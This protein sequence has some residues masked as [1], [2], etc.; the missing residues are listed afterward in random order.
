MTDVHD[1][2]QRSY[3]MSRIRGKDTKPEKTLRSLL[4]RHGFRFRLNVTGLPGKPDI[5]LPKHRTVIFVHGCYWHRHP[6]CKYATT[7]ATNAEF[8]MEKFKRN[9]ERDNENQTA[10]LGLG[11][12]V[13]VVWEC[14]LKNAQEDVLRE[15]VT[16]LNRC[17]P[18]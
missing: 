1:S 12:K 14:G 8:W 5:V 13:V 7:P 15:V 4:H 11:W 16:N 6:G 9:V 2:K 18:A 10:C 3:N 17:K